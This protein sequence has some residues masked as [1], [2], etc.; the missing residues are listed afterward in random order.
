MKIIMNALWNMFF[1]KSEEKNKFG[2]QLFVCFVENIDFCE[3]NNYN[4]IEELERLKRMKLIC[5]TKG[6]LYNV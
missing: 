4:N 2:K 6:W 1:D 5:G 3:E